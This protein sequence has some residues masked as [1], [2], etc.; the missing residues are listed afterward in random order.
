MNL[1]ESKAVYVGF[2]SQFIGIA[3]I[4]RM[5]YLGGQYNLK[6]KTHITKIFV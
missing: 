2:A 3:L 6:I 4:S 5:A 1:K